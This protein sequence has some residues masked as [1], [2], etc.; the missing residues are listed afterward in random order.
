MGANTNTSRR[1]KY[2][3]ILA[4][5]WR[6][7]RPDPVQAL[8]YRERLRQLVKR[9]AVVNGPWTDPGWSHL[10]MATDRSPYVFGIHAQ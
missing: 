2:W 5:R 8:V 4:P 10:R 6:I 7:E 3:G 9:A 1:D